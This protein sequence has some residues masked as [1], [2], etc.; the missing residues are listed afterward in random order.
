MS[1]IN[2]RTIL[3]ETLTDAKGDFSYSL[4]VSNLSPGIYFVNLQGDAY[5]KTM[6]FV[7]Q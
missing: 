3:S 6:K 2:G 5:N 1:D 4:N 7:K